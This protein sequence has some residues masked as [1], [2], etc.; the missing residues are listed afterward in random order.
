M[1]PYGSRLVDSVGFLMVSLTSLDASILPPPPT[2]DSI[3]GCG[4]QH[5]FPSAAGWSFSDESYVKLLSI[6][7]AEYH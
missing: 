7:T 3:F 1:S 5:L 4:S 6:S 2:Q